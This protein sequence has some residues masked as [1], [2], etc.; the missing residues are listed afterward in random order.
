MGFLEGDPLS[1]EQCMT[2]L[3]RAQLGRVA[4]S[5][6]ALPVVV[7]VRYMLSDG[8]LLFTATGEELTKAL[9][10]NIAA[11]Q[12]DGFDEDSGR[13][14]SVF[15][16]GPIAIVES[17]ETLDTNLSDSP[18]AKAESTLFRLNPAILSGRWIDAL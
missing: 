10:G 1:D 15:A 8:P 18:M 16:T 3:S 5:L 7:P 4:L 12:A 9:Y 6:R 2:L 17:L 11:L 14:W 13:R